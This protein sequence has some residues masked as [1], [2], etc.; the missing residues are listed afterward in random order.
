MKAVVELG[1]PAVRT[2]QASSDP[3]KPVFRVSPV[4]CNAAFHSDSSAVKRRIGEK[5]GV[6]GSLKRERADREGCEACAIYNWNIKTKG[7]FG[8]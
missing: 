7:H 6:L 8:R 3:Q 5:E 4:K 2:R 1:G